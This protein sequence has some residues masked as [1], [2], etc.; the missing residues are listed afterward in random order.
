MDGE[1]LICTAKHFAAHGSPE[2]GVNLAPVA[3]GVRD[4]RT[5]YLPPFEAAIREA[6]ALSLMPAYSEYDDVPAHANSSC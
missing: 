1:H 5:L 4:L 2:A 3:G 6:G